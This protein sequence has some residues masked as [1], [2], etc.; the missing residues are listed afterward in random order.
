M[1]MPYSDGNERPPTVAKLFSLL[2]VDKPFA[3][4]LVPIP[5][6]SEWYRR[7][8]ERHGVQAFVPLQCGMCFNWPKLYWAW[9]RTR[10][11]SDYAC[12][13]FISG[14]SW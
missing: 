8:C 4:R 5:E 11:A 1:T 9:C 13:D 3:R 14:E 7:E 2:D 6:L 12:A 10:S